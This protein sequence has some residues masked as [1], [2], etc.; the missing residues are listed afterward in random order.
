MEV[1]LK[2]RAVKKLVLVL[3]EAVVWTAGEEVEEGVRT[4]AGIAR[5]VTAR[6]RADLGKPRA[7]ILRA[8]EEWSEEWEKVKDKD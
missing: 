1:M 4:T 5:R 2:E 3:R 7:S 6:V 8:V